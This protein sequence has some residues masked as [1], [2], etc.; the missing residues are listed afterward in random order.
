MPTNTRRSITKLIGSTTCHSTGC[1]AGKVRLWRITRRV[2][3]PFP[4]GLSCHDHDVAV[5]E[6]LVTGVG[7]GVD[8]HHD[9]GASRL[10]ADHS[11]AG[12]AIGAEADE[13]ADLEVPQFLDDALGAADVAA[14]GVLDC[15]VAVQPASSVPDLCQ[16]R[17]DLGGW[18]VDRDRSGGGQLRLQYELVTGHTPRTSP[19]VVPQRL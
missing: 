15:V 17:P 2:P 14:D 9:K 3:V 8:A 16:P 4:L 7:G 18:R 11:E 1:A 6:S 5:V 13:V 19:F 10:H 12:I